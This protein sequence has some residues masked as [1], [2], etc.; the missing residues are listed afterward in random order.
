M[1]EQ[2]DG[3][4]DGSNTSA[5]L[6]NYDKSFADTKKWVQEELIDYIAPQVYFTFANSRAPYVRLLC[7]GRMFAGGK[8]CIFI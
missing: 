5:S 7:G 4:S 3:H 8:M 2:S 6:T 1:G